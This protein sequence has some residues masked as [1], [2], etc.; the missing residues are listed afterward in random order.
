MADWND[1]DYRRFWFHRWIEAGV[2][3]GMAGGLAL[4]WVFWGRS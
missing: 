3:V 1:R 2:L 4:G